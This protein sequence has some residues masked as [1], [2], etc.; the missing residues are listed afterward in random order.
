VTGGWVNVHIEELHSLYTL[1][2]IIR[3]IK[4][5]RMTWAGHVAHM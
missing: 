3:M 2:D 1:P 5:R 4:S